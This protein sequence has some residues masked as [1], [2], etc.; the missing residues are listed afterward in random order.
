M[1][2]APLAP[3]IVIVDDD[4]RRAHGVRE[5]RVLAG[6]RTLAVPWGPQ[7][8]PLI[9]L[10]AP[11]LVI[12]GIT[13]DLEMPAATI[14]AVR[15]DGYADAIVALGD[16][17]P[18]LRAAGATACVDA[19][20]DAGL[21]AALAPF[22]LGVQ[23]A[24]LSVGPGR[25][26]YCGETVVDLDEMSIMRSE[27]VLS[28]SPTACALFRALLSANGAVVSRAALQQDVWSGADVAPR[29]VYQHVSRLRRQLEVNPRRP[30]HLHTVFGR[31]YR[32]EIDRTS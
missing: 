26:V 1:S 3:T 21:D 15:A 25:L 16:A 30:R 17:S 19:S 28:M 31:G 22:A 27:H 7:V 23:R 11:R 29:L 4:V 24:A 5:S 10:L 18:S 20:S 8:R 13:G 12:V 2:L 6:H 32:L 9:H 14:R